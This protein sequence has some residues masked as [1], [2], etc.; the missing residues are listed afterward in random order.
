MEA[1]ANALPD[2]LCIPMERNVGFGR[3][4]NVGLMKVVTPF[5][6][7]LNPDCTLQSDAY[8][9]LLSAAERY[10]NA[11]IL[12]PKLY[13]APGKLGLCYRPPFHVPQPKTLIDP[14]GDVCSEFLTGAAMLLRMDV[15]RRI[16]FFDPW[17]F[18]YLEDDD[19]CI[20]ARKA[21]YSLVL[22]NDACGEHRV[23]QSSRPSPRLDY[24]RAYCATASKL[25]AL[26]KHLGVEP[27][28][29]ARHRALFGAPLALIGAL[30]TFN[31]RRIGRSL[32]RVVAAW[33]APRLLR[34]PHCIES[35]D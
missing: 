19:L 14:E 27:Y 5:A 11:A 34:Q 26:N 29:R 16:G 33:R 15:F 8:Q 20:R 35:L 10:P 30:L 24:R 18:L 4:N 7:L 9:V 25:Y 3:A 31:R 21:G 6:L 22:V 32:G 2:A 28:R 12:A 1:V 17:F 13:D 23:K